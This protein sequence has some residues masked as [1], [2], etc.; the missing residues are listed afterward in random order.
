M[1]SK[2]SRRAYIG[3]LCNTEPLV[4]QKKKGSA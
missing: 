3:V 4:E 2:G 1:T